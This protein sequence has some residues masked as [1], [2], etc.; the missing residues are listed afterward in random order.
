MQIKMVGTV[1]GGADEV[2][3]DELSSSIWTSY[4][5]V[6][7]LILTLECAHSIWA[8]NFCLSIQQEKKKKQQ[9]K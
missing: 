3:G 8:T 6:W 2:V 7:V 9:W 1:G 4:T 5:G